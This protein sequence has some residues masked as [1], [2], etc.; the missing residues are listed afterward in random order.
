MAVVAANPDPIPVIS[1]DDVLK[2]LRIAADRGRVVR[3][4]IAAERGSVEVGPASLSNSSATAESSA[5][6]AR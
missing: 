2:A 3:Y 5:T 1:A 6:T 4:N